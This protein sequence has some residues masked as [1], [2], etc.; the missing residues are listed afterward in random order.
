MALRT[1]TSLPVYDDFGNHVA[2][3]PSKR[4][5]ERRQGCWNCLS[6]ECSDIYRKRVED[7]KRR[8]ISAFLARGMSLNGA[9]IKAAATAGLL[10]DKA[11]IFGLCLKGKV[12]GDFVSC[13]HLCTSGWS[14]Q[15]GVTGSFEAGKAYDE[16][17]GF[18]YEG[19]GVKITDDG[20]VKSDEASNY[21]ATSQESA[22]PGSVYAVSEDGVS[23]VPSG[24]AV[25]I[26]K[27]PAAPEDKEPA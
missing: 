10:L 27:A 12:A 9:G 22:L 2:I 8:D 11:G 14:G 15:V 17:V 21:T 6:F 26:D 18:L 23:A 4:T 5:F 16:P 20:E 1:K 7:C 3:P 25:T 24:A 13:K 19:V